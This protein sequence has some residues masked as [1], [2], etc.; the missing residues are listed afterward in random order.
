MQQEVNPIYEMTQLDLDILNEYLFYNDTL[1]NFNKEEIDAIQES[2][3]KVIRENLINDSN[4]SKKVLPNYVSMVAEIVDEIR[5]NYSYSDTIIRDITR[6]LNRYFGTVFSKIGMK[7]APNGNISSIDLC[8][9]YYNCKTAKEDLEIYLNSKKQA[10][11][12]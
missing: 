6:M 8:I 12:R 1:F 5:R 9:N 3:K 11:Q 10:E 2:C 4:I 7:D